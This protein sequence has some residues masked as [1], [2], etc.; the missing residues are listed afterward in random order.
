MFQLLVKMSTHCDLEQPLCLFVV[1]KFWNRNTLVPHP[2]KDR[3]PSQPN[4]SKY[5][6]HVLIYC[7]LSDNLMFSVNYM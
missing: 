3:Q 6:L 7:I 4:Q 1:G 5:L 2:G